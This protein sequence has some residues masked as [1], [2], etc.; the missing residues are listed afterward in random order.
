MRDDIESPAALNRWVYAGASVSILSLLAATVLQY[1]LPVSFYTRWGYAN[2]KGVVDFSR[3]LFGGIAPSV[4]IATFSHCFV[5]F[6]MLAWAGYIISVIAGYRGGIL[7]KKHALVIIS[8]ASIALGIFWPASLSWDTYG[9]VGF[10]R[11]K[12]LYGLNPY[13][14]SIDFLHSLHDPVA[15]FQKNCAPSPYGP[16][17][18]MVSI[19]VVWFLHSVDLFWQIV[20]VKLIESIALV[21]AALAGRSI[22]NRVSPGKG[23]LAM[24]AI[25]LNPLL[26]IEGPG[27]GHND[28]LMIA[29]LIV[30][31]ALFLRKRFMLAAIF[32]GL[33]IG[34][35]LVTIAALPLMLIA[36]VRRKDLPNRI[37]VISTVVMLALAPTLLGYAVFWEG[38]GTLTGLRAQWLMGPVAQVRYHPG[39]ELSSG[40]IV[41]SLVKQW[42]LIV[43]F[44]ALSACVW[45]SKKESAWISAW[46]ILL[47]FIFFS[48]AQVCFPWYMI[49]LCAMSMTG[50]NRIHLYATCLYLIVGFTWMM[51]YTVI[52]LPMN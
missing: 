3:H 17:W 14:H 38:W 48:S 22:A 45:M 47:G 2:R 42:P 43:A 33:S 49:W 6:L 18:T 7:Q 46:A 50:W 30:G 21:A 25:G 52:P 34:I 29:L 10:A 32:L 19:L 44:L 23:D 11:M 37:L 9:Y 8:V 4:D 36:L 51:G 41:N 15:Y 13:M 31:A 1:F 16:V 35:K 40:G 5:I 27:N 26:L 24:L 28:M 39:M 12:V 20:G